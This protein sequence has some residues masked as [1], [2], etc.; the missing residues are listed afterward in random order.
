MQKLTLLLADKADDQGNMLSQLLEVMT[1]M[2]D[3]MVAMDQE[4]SL[5]DA[6]VAMLEAD[7]GT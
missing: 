2:A 6:R 5:L 3:T 4:T 1:Q 7:N